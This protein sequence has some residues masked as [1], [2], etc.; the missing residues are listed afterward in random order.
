MIVKLSINLNLYELVE[1]K[2]VVFGVLG[3]LGLFFRR[4]E[5]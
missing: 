1:V 5:K 4:M 3:K 2:R